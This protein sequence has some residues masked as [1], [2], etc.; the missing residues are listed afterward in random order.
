MIFH[1]AI[2]KHEQERRV[3]KFGFGP[4]KVAYWKSCT[5]A[6][7]PVHLW[8]IFEGLYW[9]REQT[10]WRW[11]WLNYQQTTTTTTTTPAIHHTIQKKRTSRRTMHNALKINDFI[12]YHLGVCEW[13][14]ERERERQWVYVSHHTLNRLPGVIMHIRHSTIVFADVAHK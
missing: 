12:S 6:Y 2:R 5:C 4:L 10:R 3:D 8:P 7:C 14:W 11:W 13:K 1:S 9:S